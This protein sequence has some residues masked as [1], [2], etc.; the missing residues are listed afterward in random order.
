[1]RREPARTRSSTTNTSTLGVFVASPRTQ[2]GSDASR[3]SAAT[4]ARGNGPIPGGVAW[5]G[6]GRWGPAVWSCWAGRTAHL[7]YSTFV[8]NS[9]SLWVLLA[10]RGNHSWRRV[11]SIGRRPLAPRGLGGEGGVGGRR[12]TRHFCS[13]DHKSSPDLAVA[14]ATT[15]PVIAHTAENGSTRWPTTPVSKADLRLFRV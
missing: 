5:H 14:Q 4:R 3:A 2:R 13:G 1:M 10:S 15:A 7:F 11:A 12:D 8:H 9:L 6:V